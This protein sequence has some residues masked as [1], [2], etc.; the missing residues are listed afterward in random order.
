[1]SLNTDK[2]LV[3]PAAKPG[4][5]LMSSIPLDIFTMAECGCRLES[6]RTPYTVAQASSL[7]RSLQSHQQMTDF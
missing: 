4:S 2:L 3:T 7:A 6:A 5:N 1:M